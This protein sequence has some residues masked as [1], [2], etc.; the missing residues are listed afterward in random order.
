MYGCVVFVQKQP[1]ILA[2]PTYGLEIAT[3]Q[4]VCFLIHMHSIVI[5]RIR[6][7]CLLRQHVTTVCLNLKKTI[8]C[9]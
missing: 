8:H 7:L 3:S 4:E 2:L 9:M 1:Y 6:S 5:G